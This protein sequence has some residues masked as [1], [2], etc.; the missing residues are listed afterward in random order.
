VFPSA[1]IDENTA[2][3]VRLTAELA[4]AGLLDDPAG[5]VRGRA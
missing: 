5:I 3:L 4:F 2:G 1:K